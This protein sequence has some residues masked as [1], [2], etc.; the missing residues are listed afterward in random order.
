MIEGVAAFRE[1][2]G[3]G[4]LAAALAGVT[5]LLVSTRAMTAAGALLVATRSQASRPAGQRVILQGGRWVSCQL[6]C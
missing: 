1:G 6:C 4:D 5:P 3:T 2:L